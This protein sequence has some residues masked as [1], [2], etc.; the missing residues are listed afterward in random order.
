[1]DVRWLDIDIGLG[2]WGACWIVRSWSG[3]IADNTG[4]RGDFNRCDSGVAYGKGDGVSEE[5]LFNKW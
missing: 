5:A 3:C 4:Y 2:K 1:M